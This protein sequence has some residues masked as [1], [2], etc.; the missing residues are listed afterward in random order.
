[1]KIC[2]MSR[3]V[4]A[5]LASMS[6]LSAAQTSGMPQ[7]EPIPPTAAVALL[8]IVVSDS[9]GP[10]VPNATVRLMNQ[11]NAKIEQRSDSRGLARFLDIPAATY[12]IEVTAAGFETERMTNVKLSTGEATGIEVRLFERKQIVGALGVTWKQMVCLPISPRGAPALAL[13]P[14]PPSQDSSPKNH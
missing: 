13:E 8:D 9:C 5:A 12:T 14:L 2:S 1:M 3:I 11:M 6:A 7:P 4:G 10:L